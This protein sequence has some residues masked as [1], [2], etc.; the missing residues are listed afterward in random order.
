MNDHCMLLGLSRYTKICFFLPKL[1]FR[2]PDTLRPDGKHDSLKCVCCVC[3]H[4]CC[5]KLILLGSKED[6]MRE[7][8]YLIFM[9]RR[10]FTLLTFYK[11][12]R[13][14]IE[15]S[16]CIFLTLKNCNKVC[17]EKNSKRQYISKCL[18]VQLVKIK[19]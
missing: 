15:Q 13:K 17:T 11:L 18:T 10:R 8:F 16:L 2:R 3:A 1:K 5:S 12:L 9:R 19:G 6:F 14:N 7:R 4:H